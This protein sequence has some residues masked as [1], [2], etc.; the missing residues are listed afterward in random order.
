[1]GVTM[2]HFLAVATATAVFAI[3]TPSFAGGDGV[4][5]AGGCGFSAARLASLMAAEPTA[6]M[7]P[8]AAE[9]EQ[10]LTLPQIAA[11]LPHQPVKQPKPATQ[12]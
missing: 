10:G 1:M 4:Y 8:A 9:V 3:A 11:L 5:G 7:Q 6:P 2:R 12:R